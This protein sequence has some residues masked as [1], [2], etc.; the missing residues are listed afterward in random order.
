VLVAVEEVV[1]AR[2]VRE[3]NSEVVKVRERLNVV[4]REPR[5]GGWKGF[6]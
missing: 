6:L 2:R 1:V 4:V 5:K 3:V